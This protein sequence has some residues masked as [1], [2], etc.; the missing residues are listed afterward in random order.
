[1]SEKYNRSIRN[2]L[3]DK[4]LQLKFIVYF[5]LSGWLGIVVL[6]ILI[7]ERLT[8]LIQTMGQIDQLQPHTTELALDVVGY[9]G[10]ALVAQLLFSAA[11]AI[12]LSHRIAGPSRAILAYIDDLKQGQFDSQ[13]VLRKKD[14]LQPIMASL[15][16]LGAIL[17]A[18]TKT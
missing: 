11:L 4:P 7:F 18:K 1:M 14:D 16:E 12:Y 9:M 8:Q 13:R 17:K 15:R 3:V 6:F 5:V 2:I 10:V